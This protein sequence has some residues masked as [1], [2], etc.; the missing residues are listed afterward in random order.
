[1][2]QSPT[3]TQFRRFCGRAA[4]ACLAVAAL[5]SPPQAATAERHNLGAGNVEIWNVAGSA[6]LVP[7]SGNDVIVTVTRGGR[8]GE[9]LRIATGDLRGRSTLRVIYPGS[10]VVYP[11]LG[12]GTNSSTRISDDG[13]FGLDWKTLFG[14][15]E[16]RVSG[17][18]SG[19]EAWVDLE[20][21]VPVGTDL[22]LHVLAGEMA[23][24]GVDGRFLLDGGASAV[25][26]KGVKGEL[27]VDTGSGD[28]EVDT[29]RGALSVD[30]G[31]GSVMVL[32]QV[33]GRLHVDTGSGEVRVADCK[34][35]GVLV[36]T[37]S[38]DV[39][40]RGITSPDVNVDTGSG[41]V[42]LELA[43]SSDDVLVDTGSG[44]VTVGV[45]RDY[46]ARF[47]VETGSGD[48]DIDVPHT[49]SQHSRDEARGR[50]GDGRGQIRIDT[51]SGSVR[52]RPLSSSSGGS[53]SWNPYGLGGVLGGRALE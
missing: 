26:A 43:T 28:V 29:G 20:I 49:S 33:G 35:D 15:R 13:T 21:A 4:A 40:M 23:A 11:A 37:G 22:K 32:N 5:A 48:I 16:V 25:R 53:S 9:K 31:S 50:I 27:I 47:T 10:R 8:D 7:A 38:G 39:T 19:I 45:P 17:R 12:S 2:P 34:V 52:I 18:G 41:S 14:G 30:T 6:R 3:W 46:S 44:S 1:M 51:G 42:L 24:A 36:D